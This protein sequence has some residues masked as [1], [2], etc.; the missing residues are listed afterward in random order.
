MGRH[1]LDAIFLPKSV[2]VVGA[3]EK[4]NS[5]GRTVLWNLMNTPFGGPVYPVNPTRSSVLGIKAYPKLSALPEKPDLIVVTTPAAIIPGL[6]SEAADLGVPGAII[7]SAGFKEIG[8]AG[9][10][11]ERQVLAQ[12][13]RGNMRLIGPNCLGVLSP[14]HGSNPS[15]APSMVRKGSVAFLS[16]SGALGCAV[17]DWSLR[18]GVGF[19]SFVSI[20][21][22]LDVGWGD[23]ISYFGDDPNTKSIVIYMESIGDARSFLSAAREVALTKPIIIIKPGRTAG[24][25]KAAASHTG[26]LTGSDDVLD[27]AFKRCGVLRVN[28]ISEVFDMSEVLGKQPR[29]QGNR[30]TIITNAGGPGVLATDALL[31]TGGTLAEISKETMDELNKNLPSVWSHN[32]PIDVIGDA[33]PELYTKALEIAGR[34]KNSDGLLVILTPQAMTDCTGTAEKLKAFGHI[35]GKPVLASWMGGNIVAEGEVLLNKADIPTFAYPDT[36]ARAFTFM[37]QYSENLRALYETPVPSADPADLESGRAKANTLLASV[38]KSGRTILTE[39]ESKDLLGCYGIPTVITKIAKT[40][41]AAAKTAKEIGFPIVLKLYSET[42]THKTDVGGVQLNLKDEAEVRKAFNDIKQ[43]VTEKKGAEHF[44]GVTVQKMI[45]LG[46]GYEIILGSS[47]DPQFGPVLLFGMGGQLVEIFKDKA[48]ALPPLNTTL[49]RRMMETTKIYKA[50]KGVRGRKPVDLAALE[51]LMVGFSQLVAEQRWIKEI[52]INPLFASGDDL[53]ALDARVI[54]HDPKTAEDQLPKL[55][56]CPYPTQYVGAWKMK[57]GTK[58]TIRPIRPE[59]EPVM[60]NFHEG[61]SERSVYLRYFSPLKL[62]ERVA[63]TRLIRICFNDYDREIA[64]VA[65]RNDS[66][67]K[68]QIMGV[69][70]LSRLHGSN[71]GEF[72]VI[73]TDAWQRKGLGTEL[74]KRMVQIAKDEKLGRLVAYTLRENKDMQQMCKKVGFKVRTPAGES[75]CVIEMEL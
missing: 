62:S 31:T 52:D 21:S 39:A 35:E 46:D 51:K 43:A 60:V 72:A 70:R 49:A 15:F 20:G 29:P 42:I 48:L 37:Y 63:H 5:V 61:L 34:D 65:E 47:I 54:L 38:K 58:V 66:K 68:S 59:D 55:S 11:L 30:L 27:A 22:M 7:I 24:A 14:L 71:A 73:V 64:L 41:A 36:A 16:Q 69:V 75:E 17:L 32:N 67:G 9:V 8:P 18:E 28:D 19:S 10:E 74:T 44:Q 45:K 40:E 3:T 53:V 4:P 56:I 13:R 2:A 57:D 26:S 6:M 12:V 50:L 33:S 23:L 1:P 25:A